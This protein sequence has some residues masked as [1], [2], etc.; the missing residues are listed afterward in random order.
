[1][2]NHRLSITPDSQ[3]PF[4]AA[5]NHGPALPAHEARGPRDKPTAELHPVFSPP[6]PLHS[7]QCALPGLNG[8]EVATFHPRRILFVQTARLGQR[9]NQMARSLRPMSTRL[10]QTSTS[11]VQRLSKPGYM[12]DLLQTTG[13][14]WWREE[15][16]INFILI[17]LTLRKNFSF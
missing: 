15:L 2:R 3:G 6:Q 4:R 7:Q 9:E 16:P 5:V 14:T 1:M 11:L 10:D 13:V 17:I 8:P 12:L